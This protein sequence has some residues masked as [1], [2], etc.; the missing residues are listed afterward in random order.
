MAYVKTT[1]KHEITCEWINNPIKK[2]R[3]TYWIIKT[4]QN[5]TSTGNT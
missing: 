5:S 4:R 2:Q 1:K 3:L